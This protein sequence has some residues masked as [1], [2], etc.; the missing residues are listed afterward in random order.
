MGKLLVLS[1]QEV[2]AILTRHGFKEVRKRGSHVVMQ[3]HR[4]DGTT[5][6]PVPEHKELRISA[7]QSII[8]QSGLSRSEFEAKSSGA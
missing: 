8:R 7:L 2:C 4:I 6:I 1:G 5:T 3:Q